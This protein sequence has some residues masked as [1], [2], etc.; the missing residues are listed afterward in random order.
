MGLLSF[1][2]RRNLADKR[3]QDAFL[4]TQAYHNT[5]AAAAPIRGEIAVTPSSRQRDLRFTGT[6]PVGGN[7]KT[8][9]ETL[10]KARGLNHSQSLGL[11]APDAGA[12]PAPAVPLFRSYSVE[13]PSTAPNGHLSTAAIRLKKT[14]ARS[15]DS[16]RQ[17][18]R[19][20]LIAE[21]LSGSSAFFKPEQ[22]QPS[23]QRVNS[24]SSATGSGYKDILD[25]QSE[26]KPLDFKTR[27]KATGA[28][29][30]G[31]D[32]A[33]RNMRENGCDLDSPQIQSFY[34]QDLYEDALRKPGSL[35]NISRPYRK[36]QA[37]LESGLRT[38]SLN[39]SSVF[40]YTR[41]NPSRL[42]QLPSTPS[43]NVAQQ[44][45]RR[46]NS[47]G[48]LSRRQSSGRNG[49]TDRDRALSIKSEATFYQGTPLPGSP[50]WLAAHSPKPLPDIDGPLSPELRLE[51]L[52]AR[53]RPAE[54]PS[55][56]TIPP[57]KQTRLQEPAEKDQEHNDQQ[58]GGPVLGQRSFPLVAPPNPKTR[59]WTSSSMISPTTT[60]FSKLSPPHTP[61]SQDH[62]SISSAGYHTANETTSLSYPP[63]RHRT[64]SLS[65]S[66]ITINGP[67]GHL[68]IS[69]PEPSDDIDQDA[70]PSPCIKIHPAHDNDPKPDP[71][72]RS[73]TSSY[74]G[75]LQTDNDLPPSESGAMR[76]SSLR[77]WSISSTT[78]TTSDT[79][80]SS[81][82][83]QRPVSRHTAQTS[84]DLGPPFT[85]NPNVSYDSL[86]PT[87]IIHPSPSPSP[88]P[89]TSATF[90][91]DDYLSSD[92]D[93]LEPQRPRGEGEEELLFSSQ[94][95]GGGFHLPGLSDALATT[96]PLQPS[97]KDDF[98]T[99]LRSSA[100]LPLGYC[101]RVYAD[102]LSPRAPT[103]R[104]GRFILDT[105]ADS[106]E[107][108]EED[109]DGF[110]GYTVSA[111]GL[112]P[113]M[114]RGM[115]RLSALGDMRHED[116]IAEEVSV[117]DLVR[118]RKEAKAR[119]RAL[120]GNTL[121]SNRRENWKGKGVE[122]D[123]EDEQHA[124]V[125]C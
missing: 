9:L 73:L 50:L 49:R 39:S 52:T 26:F 28:R 35:T 29:D 32:V 48:I 77:N 119:K 46:P 82:P 104:R 102:P 12:A 108:E 4:I 113:P 98:M 45:D 37:S 64:P 20:S 7:G 13:R 123:Y 118:M 100:S 96:P 85:K 17:S 75:K 67:V 71:R 19:Q 25:A 68:T 11:L 3:Q 69:T 76:S 41:R 103:A 105:A 66:L 47:S 93:S 44:F 34:A 2:T 106:E 31:E 109:E 97:P 21:S 62:S 125:E 110:G 18:R 112:Y 55:S 84:V 92:D 58:P 117:R 99:R 91:M 88:L 111:G 5:T 78:P 70:A 36:D 1:L 80:T 122:V 79:S 94:G 43:S 42:S 124:D 83:F 63:S 40:G 15:H 65:N 72:T 89:P 38:R 86:H 114:R 6:F 116:T 61:H 90:N 14:S 87:S 53:S 23:F 121:R 54:T 95:Y 60:N 16:P 115:R 24:L 10:T 81:N 27:V 57:L 107:D 101:D 33:D 8:D 22:E 56:S 30:Y 74:H 120:G 59:P 51:S